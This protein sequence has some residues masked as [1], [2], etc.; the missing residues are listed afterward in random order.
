MQNNVV[1]WQ[2]GI[3]HTAECSGAGYRFN[4]L[5]AVSYTPRYEASSSSFSSSVAIIASQ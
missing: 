3:P 1:R 2:V 5:S 4:N